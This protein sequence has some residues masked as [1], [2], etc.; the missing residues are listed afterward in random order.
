MYGHKVSSN[1]EVIPGRLSMAPWI[2]RTVAQVAGGA[3]TV[4]Y[5]LVE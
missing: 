5:A 2:E 1:K 4:A 3:T